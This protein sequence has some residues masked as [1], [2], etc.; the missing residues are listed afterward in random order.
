MSEAK[1]FKRKDIDLEFIKE[2][3][4]NMSTQEIANHLGVARGTVNK[5]AKELGL[6]KSKIPFKPLHE[7]ITKEIKGIE[8]YGI[9]SLGRVVNLST[10][11]LLKPKIDNVGYLKNVFWLN[12]ERVEKRTHRLLAEHFIPNPNNKPFV[13]HIDGV[14]TNCTIDNLEWVTPQENNYH[15]LV[16][17]LLKT[18]EDHPC[19]KISE[20]QAIFIISELKEG[21]TVSRIV[22][23]NEFATKSI[24]E[25][26]K[27]GSRWK[28]LHR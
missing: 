19:S 4:Y 22:K 21:K 27:S 28:H 23:E 18:G 15:A 9:T 20:T 8:G 14:K 16:N 11:T 1:L 3:F 24:V 13:N 26:I 17:N 6:R 10:N 25:K 12:G 2:N 5:R 7:E